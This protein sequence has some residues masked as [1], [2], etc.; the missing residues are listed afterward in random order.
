MTEATTVDRQLTGED[1]GEKG[2]VK[3]AKEHIQRKSKYGFEIIFTSGR[4]WGQYF[5]DVDLLEKFRSGAT[6]IL[7]LNSYTA[8]RLEMIAFVRRLPNREV[9]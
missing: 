7:D 9:E 5:T 3:S 2:Q 8:I 6:G 1:E 4:R